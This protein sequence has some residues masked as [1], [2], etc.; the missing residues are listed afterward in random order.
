MEFNPKQHWKEEICMYL[1]YRLDARDYS[2]YLAFQKI[3]TTSVIRQKAI[4]RWM[5]CV[6]FLLGAALFHKERSVIVVGIVLVSCVLWMFCSNK[7]MNY[8]VKKQIYKK[9]CKDFQTSEKIDICF[10]DSNFSCKRKQ[11]QS[12]YLYSDITHCIKFQ[13]LLILTLKTGEVLILPKR[14]FTSQREWESF[15]ITLIEGV[16]SNKKR[17]GK[18][19]D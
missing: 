5:V 14:I 4:T 10:Y 11:L 15:Y 7:F 1:S 17:G 2:S 19:Y 18:S 6:V 16:F 13:G 3:Q 9:I 12:E 8:I